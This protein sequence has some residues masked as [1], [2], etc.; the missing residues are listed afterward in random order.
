[1]RGAYGIALVLFLTIVSLVVL[2]GS[3]AAETTWCC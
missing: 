2:A 3:A 1:M